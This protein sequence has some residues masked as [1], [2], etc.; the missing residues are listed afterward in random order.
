MKAKRGAPSKQQ[1]IEN[2][3]SRMS[4]KQIRHASKLLFENDYSV[5]KLAF[6]LIPDCGTPYCKRIVDSKDVNLCDRCL[7]RYNHLC[8]E[9]KE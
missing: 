5:V 7:R 1:S 8:G 9:G 2:L 3:K 6:K 4:D